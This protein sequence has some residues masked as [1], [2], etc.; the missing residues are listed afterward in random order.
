MKCPHC[1]SKNV[2]YAHHEWFCLDCGEQWDQY[3][4]NTK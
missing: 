4:Q 1:G 3:L 2:E